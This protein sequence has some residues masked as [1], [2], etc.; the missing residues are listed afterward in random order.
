MPTARHGDVE[1]HWLRAGDPAGEP[2]LLIM[3]LSGSHRDWHRLLPHI[4][5]C[6]V[7]L[8]D[9]R[10]TGMSSPVGGLLSMAD[11]VRDAV[12]VLDAAGL[13][14]AHVHGTSMGGMIAQHLALTHRER[15]RSLVLSAT[16][17]GGMLDKP[18]WR[19][20]AATALRPL[21]GS[22]RTWPM[23]APMVYSERTRLGAPERVKQDLRIRSEH[24]TVAKTTFAQ[25]AAIAR[26]DTRKRLH[27]LAGI[28]ATVIHGDLDLLVPPSHGR[29]LGESIPGARF[30]LL[31][32]SAHILTTD[33]EHGLAAAMRDHLQRAVDHE[34]SA[35][36]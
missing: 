1:V 5:D 4:E 10:G 32:G 16:T 23:V 18:P 25:M 24:A 21:L 28:P 35:V 30:V 8:F 33:D 31:E 29:A 7:V 9:N 3:G 27:E 20:L 17:P 36:T 6:D 13:P 14:A 2:V 15:V 19:M 26:H 12:A 22:K 11:M 34:R